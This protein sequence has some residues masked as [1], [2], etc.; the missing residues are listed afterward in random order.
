MCRIST[1][2]KFQVCDLD[3]KA[4]EGC[5]DG[6]AYFFL[7]VSSIRQV[8]ARSSQCFRRLLRPLTKNFNVK[9]STL[10]L[11]L[12]GH[13]VGQ[14]ST[15]LNFS[16]VFSTMVSI[17]S[18]PRNRRYNLFCG[19]AVLTPGANADAVASDISLPVLWYR[20]AKKEHAKTFS[21][22]SNQISVY[23]VFCDTPALTQTCLLS[24]KVYIIWCSTRNS[25]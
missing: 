24:H 13:W 5:G 19:T 20:P 7:P 18:I 21:Y 3:L 8:Q 9:F 11:W 16:P 4:V 2:I 15:A 25:S 10:W 22:K 6:T 17:R 23:S 12:R 14:D 1:N